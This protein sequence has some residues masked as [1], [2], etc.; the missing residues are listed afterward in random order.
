MHIHLAESSTP[1]DYTAFS[2]LGCVWKAGLLQQECSPPIVVHEIFVNQTLV[3]HL[4]KKYY[5]KS[6]CKV[7]N[8]FVEWT[9]APC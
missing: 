2:H 9:T 4:L 7:K 6:F 5:R 3:L 8:F 1:L